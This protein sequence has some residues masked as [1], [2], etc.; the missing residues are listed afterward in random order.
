MSA[1]RCDSGHAPTRA[2]SRIVRS[3]L[4]LAL[5]IAL[6]VSRLFAQLSLSSAIQLALQN[7]PK[8]KSAQNDLQKAEAGLGI[9]RDIY[10][11]SVVLGGGLGDS[12]GITLTVPTIFTINAQSLVFSMQQRSYTHAAR[13]DLQ[14]SRFALQST[15]DQVEEDTVITYVSMQNDQNVLAAL[16][17][18]YEDASKLVS[19][20]QDRVSAKLDSPLELKK[21]QRG[22]LQIKLQRMHS[23]DDLAGLREH[24]EQLTGL[25]ADQVATV[26]DTDFALP[27]VNANTVTVGEFP[28]DPGIHAA[29]LNQQAKALRARGDAQYT[30]KPLVTFGA[31]YGRISP[32]QNVSEFYNLHGNYNTL[33]AGIQIQF[34]LMDKVRK[35]AARQT[36]LDASRAALDLQGSQF[37]LGTGRAK[38]ERA[39]PELSAKA[40]LAELDYEIASDELDA[41]TSQQH[42]STGGPPLT[43]KDE[44]NARIL[45]D[46]RRLD[47]LD[48]RFQLTKAEI[49][50]LRQTGRL[51]D[52]IH[53]AAKPLPVHP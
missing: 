17:Q 43:P 51:E 53:S 33:S 18:Q 14:A 12:Y 27:R 25:S 50:W 22:A 1:A 52:W 13:L 19:I 9:M 36:S 6:P 23:E 4:L 46:Q 34:P 44:Q 37:D 29:W 30:W 20:V 11:P 28:E 41:T 48:A 32:I 38:L 39:L 45:A 16:S 31:Q 35:Q 15:R 47:L 26:Q 10:V 3:C 40:Q 42:A 8:I 5:L 21:A 24:M 7:S 49:S 2:T